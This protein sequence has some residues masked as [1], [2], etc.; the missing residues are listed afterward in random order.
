MT[1]VDAKRRNETR[2][3]RR[4][5]GKRDPKSAITQ[6]GIQVRVVAL[7]TVVAAVFV[8]L[9][10]RLWYLQVITSEDSALSA[11]ASSTR[12][13]DLPP[14]R[15]VIY[16][17]NGKVLAN[18]VPGLNVT[19]V[20]NAI[21][22]EK[23]EELT[24]I[25][26]ADEEAVLAQYDAAF[27]SGNQY[28]PM[29]VK[30]NATRED[31]M[32]VSERTEEFKGLVVNEDY[33]RNYPENSLASHV[34]GYTGAVTPEE[35]GGGGIY[36]GLEQAAVV[37]KG[38]IELAYEDVLRG[39]P[40][41]KEY[42]VDALGRE[43]EVRMADGSRYDGRDEE[44][45]E[46]GE[47]AR[48]TEP[49][50]GKDVVLTVDVELQKTAEKELDAALLRAQENGYAGSGGA[51]IAM[52]PRNGEILASTS[53]PDFDP[54]LFVGGITGAEEVEQFDYLNSEY[55]NAPFSNRAIAGTYPAASTFKV[56]T[57]MAGLVSGV[58][59]AATA[60]TDTG[61]CW[62]PGG[63]TGGCWQSWRENGGYGTHGTQ[64]Y[65]EALMDSNNKFFYEVADR[66]WNA[67]DDEDWLPKFYERFGFGSLT[68]IDLPG[69]AAGRVPTREWQEE[70][71]GTSEDKLW[72]V[73]R[74]VNMAIGQ[75]DLLATP[76]QLIRGYAAIE[77]GGTLVTPHVAKEI[78]DQSG[79]TVEKIEPEPAARSDVSASALE[80]TKD[81]L[82]KVTEE[83]GTAEWPFEGSRL[84]MLGKTGTGELTGGRFVNWYVGWAETEGRPLI[85]LAMV[86][87]GGAF[88][89]GSEVTAAPAVRHVIEAF[90]GMEQSPD[91]PFRTAEAPLDTAG[92]TS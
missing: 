4:P 25:L 91:D 11:H 66:I 46:Q 39:T 54:Q 61:E 35:L 65:A 6:A 52:D 90:Y 5:D 18:N 16:D 45:P 84:P 41:R 13:T 17:R 42:N 60:V 72:T 57:G 73:G 71:G 75:G 21:P 32:Y 89:E 69:E 62:R 59:D 79:R 23:V 24:G 53:R 38:G 80:E 70:A 3:D 64:N 2:R 49:V 85:V 92:G 44:I 81:G 7:A 9:G 78:R 56:F 82:R 30:E 27:S 48:V 40:G 20:P 55:A 22:R 76:A 47:P 26:G 1:R 74:W 68:G 86:E 12:A 10:F 29:L 37:G 88:E 87:D 14:E 8:T 36:E 33:V 51:L 83:G 63:A 34:L 15:G 67:T 43:V 58:I 19:I 50:P 28:S 77:N 31:V